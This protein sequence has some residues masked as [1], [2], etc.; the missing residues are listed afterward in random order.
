MASIESALLTESC[1]LCNIPWGVSRHSPEHIIPESIGGR[2]TVTG[3]ICESCNN[4]S[5]GTWDKEL[6]SQLK[7]F[8]ALLGVKRQKGK[9]P[10]FD[11]Q[12]RAGE[13]IRFEV[14]GTLSFTGKSTVT[15]TIDPSK[16]TGNVS[17]RARTHGQA[18]K[19]MEGLKNK[20]LKM[21]AKTVTF[22]KRES[23]QYFQQQVPIQTSFG[24]DFAGKSLVKSVWALAA[25]SEI[26]PSSCEKAYDYLVNG[27]ETCFGYFYS[28]DL[29][30]SR[31][32]DIIHCV[33]IKGV[34]SKGLLLGYVEY[35]SVLRVVVCLSENYSGTEFINTYSINPTTAEVLELDVDLNFGA[36]EIKD[37]YDHKYFD[38]D[39]LK[40]CLARLSLLS[41]Q[42]S[43]KLNLQ[44]YLEQVTKDVCIEYGFDEEQ[45]LT[46]EE[47]MM[48]CN[49][50]I[51]LIIPFYERELGLQRKSAMENND[52]IE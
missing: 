30:S 44:K 15:D 28:R 6:S 8:S 31:P 23:T 5:G 37:I 16:G 49:R 51:E 19:I 35:F 1:A 14:D 13:S 10:F 46:D 48:F 11:F 3:F 47:Y 27:G 22:S 42:R 32:A 7:S 9:K 21:G 12:T 34:P 38:N 45:D 36:H 24:G 25:L 17:V 4:D 26:E 20:Y 52:I 43:I 50:I 2:K 39:E 40:N 33:A 41:C 18:D 29:L